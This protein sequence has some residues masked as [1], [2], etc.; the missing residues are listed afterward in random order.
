[1]SFYGDAVYDAVPVSEIHKL[2]AVTEGD[3]LMLYLQVTRGAAIFCGQ[4]RHLSAA[5]GKA[6]LLWYFWVK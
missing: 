6:K 2:L 1:F 3:S 5:K 4:S